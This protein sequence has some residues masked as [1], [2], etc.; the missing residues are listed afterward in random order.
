MWA[1]AF[2]RQGSVWGEREETT[3]GGN[4]EARKN[5][6]PAKRGRKI[7]EKPKGDRER[8]PGTKRG[9]QKRK[10]EIQEERSGKRT[11]KQ[12]QRP[13]IHT[14]GTY[15]LTSGPKRGWG[16]RPPRGKQ[17]RAA[18]GLGHPTQDAATVL[19][20]GSRG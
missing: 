15:T 17:R 18:Q 5:G 1:T 10:T 6:G 9:Q 12:R 14:G 11:Q 7:H 20:L 19:D 3:G 2:H 4:R 8:E 13:E 16:R